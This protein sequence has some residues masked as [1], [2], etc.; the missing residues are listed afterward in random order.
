VNAECKTTETVNG[1][2]LSKNYSYIW[3]IIF[4]KIPLH[5]NKDY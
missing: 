4:Y 2:K 5:D 1:H 3:T